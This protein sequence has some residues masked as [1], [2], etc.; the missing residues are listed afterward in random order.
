MGVSVI[1]EDTG[2]QFGKEGTDYTEYSPQ[3]YA[4]T[5]YSGQARRSR[6]LMPGRTGP[7]GGREQEAEGSYAKGCDTIASHDTGIARYKT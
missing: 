7:E 3:Y 5:V 1:I 2:T 4:A 6:Y